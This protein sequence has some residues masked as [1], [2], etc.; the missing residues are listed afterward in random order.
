LRGGSRCG[1][2]RRLP[3]QHHLSAERR[4]FL[5]Q[6]SRASASSSFARTGYEARSV[7]LAPQPAFVAAARATLRRF[8]TGSLSVAE[9]QCQTLGPGQPRPA[10]TSDVSRFPVPLA[11]PHSLLPMESPTSSNSPKNDDEHLPACQLA[12]CKLANPPSTF[13]A[14]R[15]RGAGTAAARCG[16]APVTCLSHSSATRCRNLVFNR[17]ASPAISRTSSPRSC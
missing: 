17:L 14:K 5:S 11:S 12:T 6:A 4:V 13:Y 8:A 10:A 1:K 15:I 7:F 2:P 16:N 9:S 3:A